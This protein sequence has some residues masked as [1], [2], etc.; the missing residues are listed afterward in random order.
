LPEARVRPLHIT[1]YLE[2]YGTHGE[3]IVRTGSWNTGEH[4][5]VGFVQWTG[6]AAQKE[7]RERTHTVSKAV[8]DARWF[9]GESEIVN[10][11]RDRLLEE[12]M[13]RLLRAETSC[14]WY[15]GEAW[16]DRCHADLT[17]ALDYLARARDVAC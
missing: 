3:V 2:R 12:A 9:A 10:P 4:S 14:H 1:E 15:W 13:W 16:V 6:S 7:A 8:H 11:E 5:G 17:A